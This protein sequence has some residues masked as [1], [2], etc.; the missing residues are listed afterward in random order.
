[1][2]NAISKMTK[3]ETAQLLQAIEDVSVTSELHYPSI[4]TLS[5]STSR[6]V[7]QCCHPHFTGG[8]W[9]TEA[10][11]LSKTGQ[12]SYLLSMPVLPHYL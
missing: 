7:G 1:M 8:E 5:H 6:K 4:S 9:G 10:Q 11:N 3:Q 12:V 2:L